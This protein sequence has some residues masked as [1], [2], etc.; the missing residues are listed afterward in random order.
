MLVSSLEYESELLQTER[1]ILTITV[2]SDA[3]LFI[4]NL[5]QCLFKVFGSTHE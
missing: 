3:K 2:N 5:I 4:I 1:N